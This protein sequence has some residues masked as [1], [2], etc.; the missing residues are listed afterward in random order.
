MA[1]GRPK[2]ELVVTATERA[3]LEQWARRPK[4]VVFPAGQDTDT[5]RKSSR[6]VRVGHPAVAPHRNRRA[7]ER[8][9]RRA[10]DD[11]R[12]VP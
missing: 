6:E 12:R 11:A 2:A 3:A 9:V 5:R 8:G 4:T 10:Q 1:L 7:G